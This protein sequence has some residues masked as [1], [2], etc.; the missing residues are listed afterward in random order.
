M[1]ETYCMLPGPASHSPAMPPPHPYTDLGSDLC[2]RNDIVNQDFFR[3]T[4][5]LV[6]FGD[7]WHLNVHIP[8]ILKLGKKE[9]K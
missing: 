9:I 1:N 4:L 5:F 2:L 6:K 3:V 7:W 8:V